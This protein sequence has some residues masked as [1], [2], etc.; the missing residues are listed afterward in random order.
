MIYFRHQ[1]KAAAGDSR[2]AGLHPAQAHLLP[3]AGPQEHRGHRRGQ[4]ARGRAHRRG[5]GRGAQVQEDRA[6]GACAEQDQDRGGDRAQQR[7][8]RAQAGAET[9]LQHRRAHEEVTVKT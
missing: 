5:R 9:Q 2:E 1:A 8:P 3:Q 4:R 7:R 6:L